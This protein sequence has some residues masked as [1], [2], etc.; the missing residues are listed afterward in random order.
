MLI[1]L[2][3]FEENLIKFSVMRCSMSYTLAIA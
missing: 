1:N 3:P 2:L